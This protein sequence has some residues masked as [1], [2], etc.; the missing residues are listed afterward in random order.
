VGGVGL[1]ALLEGTEDGGNTFDMDEAAVFLKNL[2]KPTHMGAFKLVGQID[3]EGD[4]GDRVLGSVGA[5]A[6]E[7]GVTKSF[8][9]DLI[10]SQIAGIGGGL[11]IVEGSSLNRAIFQ[12]VNRITESRV[13]AKARRI[14]LDL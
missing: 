12:S 6:Y 2:E 7:N 3:G 14:K 11:S 9:A 8:Y 10:D 13:R 4:G 1:E 5:V